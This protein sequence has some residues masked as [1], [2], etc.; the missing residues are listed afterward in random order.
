M[1]IAFEFLNIG[2]LNFAESAMMNQGKNSVKGFLLLVAYVVCER[3]HLKW[4]GKKLADLCF[5]FKCFRYPCRRII[6]IFTDI[7]FINLS[8]FLSL[9][10]L[11]CVVKSVLFCY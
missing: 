11:Y 3:V 10:K 2:C 9:E 5:S 7:T 4:K 6:V 8:S 1:S